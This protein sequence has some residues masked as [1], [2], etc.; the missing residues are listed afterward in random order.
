MNLLGKIFTVIILLMSI[1]FLTVSVAVFQ[2]HRVWRDIALKNKKE[3]ENLQDRVKAYQ[4]EIESGRDR[5]AHEQAARRYAL[6]A[7][8]TKYEQVD[9][10]YQ[11]REQEYGKLLQEA[12]Q[13]STVV[14]ATAQ[15]LE[16]TMKSNEALRK[17]LQDAQLA[18]DTVFSSVV[19]LTDA[20]NALE[21]TRQVLQERNDELTQM[22]TLAKGWLD[23]V[24]IDMHAPVDNSAPT[25]DGK[26]VSI[27]AKN[28][29]EIS[30]G[31]DDGLKRGHTLEV[32][33]GN[34]YL[35]RVVVKE[36]WP[37]RAVVEIIPEFRKGI[38][39]VGD[40]VATKFG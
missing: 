35:G 11:V 20:K 8:Q 10:R 26:V 25:V 13:L 34:S 14:A 2:T 4:T 3:I 28:L 31:A 16:N 9:A 15:T 32:F 37:D 33:R 38:I 21:G 1:V 7:L 6:A 30:I 5:L 18:R 27:G 29:M 22:Y 19:E 17:N 36:T 39:K 23:R 12:G 40:S 24:G